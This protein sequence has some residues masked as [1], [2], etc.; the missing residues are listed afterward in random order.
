[1]SNFILN[2]LINSLYSIGLYVISF[3]TSRVIFPAGIRRSD[4]L[5]LQHKAGINSLHSLNTGMHSGVNTAFLGMTLT[6]SSFFLMEKSGIFPHLPNDFKIMA[7]ILEIVLWIAAV[8]MCRKTIDSK[9]NDIVEHIISGSH[10]KTDSS[11]INLI[12]CIIMFLGL[13]S[14]FVYFS[15]LQDW[16][17][18][19]EILH[20]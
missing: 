9:V 17:W 15:L 2:A 10:V 1:M 14:C 4:K 12:D 6:I 16:S 5:T 3:L 11:W 18:V 7:L 13:F 8:A 20:P 19:Y